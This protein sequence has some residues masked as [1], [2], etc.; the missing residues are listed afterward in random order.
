VHSLGQNA[1]RFLGAL[2]RENLRT[3]R[4]FDHHCVD[5]AAA[6]AVHDRFTFR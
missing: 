2:K 6:N 3:L 5:F 1:I 4:P